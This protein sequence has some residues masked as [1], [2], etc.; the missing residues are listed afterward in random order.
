M[1]P[2]PL[3][4]PFNNDNDPLVFSVPSNFPVSFV[5]FTLTFTAAGG[6]YNQEFQYR[7]LVGHPNILLVDDDGGLDEHTYYIEAMES[8]ELPYHIWDV[9]S[10]GSPASMLN[11]YLMIIWFTGDTRTDPMTAANVDGLI[12][13]LDFGARLLITSQDFVQRLTE[14][15]DPD[16]ITLLNNYLKVAYEAP[17]SNHLT[18]G[19][20]GTPFNGLQVLTAG[21]GGAGNQYSMDALTILGGGEEMLLYGS[22][23]RAGVGVSGDYAAITVGFGIEGIYNG[24]PGY[25]TREDIID[26]ALTFLWGATGTDDVTTAI[27]EKFTLSQNYPNPFNASTNISFS[28]R[29][30]G[31][32]KI[33]IYD[34]LGRVVDVPFNEFNI[35]G[36]HV[37]NWNG[38][39][40]TSGIYFYRLETANGSYLKRMTL[41]K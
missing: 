14:R 12:S 11:Q 26:A 18:V 34:L 1:G 30:A 15:G 3:N 28:L 6:D 38:N 39:E 2:Q 10:Q 24:Y 5:E 21:N 25:D 35:A 16:D 37:V 31:N 29:E 22:G 32:V 17:E 19:V 9:S 27:P 33:V 20:A 13:Y 8:L 23:N 41:L 36:N 7:V 4:T 40:F